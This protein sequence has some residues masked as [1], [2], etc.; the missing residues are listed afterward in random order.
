MQK[1]LLFLV[2]GTFVGAGIAYGAVKL[3]T[4]DEGTVVCVNEHSNGVNGHFVDSASECKHNETA[5]T[6]VGPGG[7]VAHADEADHAATADNADTLDGLDSTA[8]MS[9]YIRETASTTTV[10]GGT[11]VWTSNCDPGKEALSFG[12]RVTN[13]GS[14]SPRPV[15]QSDGESDPANWQIVIQNQDP[16][17]PMNTF[18]HSQCFNSPSIATLAPT[19]RASTQGPIATDG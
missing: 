11:V 2:V 18:A 9:G 1:L 3:T 19:G 10:P 7:S 5:H 15:I 6:L 13:L 4:A 14:L 8:F 17:T 12:V 16:D